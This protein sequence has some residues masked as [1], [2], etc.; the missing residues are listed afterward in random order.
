MAAKD[1]HKAKLLE[2]LGNPDNNFLS[3]GKLST[4]VLGFAKEQG[5]HNVFTAAELE[6]IEREALEIRR[7]KYAKFIAAADKGLLERAKKGDPT[8]VKLVYQRFEGWSEKVKEEVEG[9]LTVKIV[10][11]SEVESDGSPDPE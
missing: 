8:A 3:K 5:I 4:E 6:D 1:R 7:T 2:Y 9:S 11:F 10:Q